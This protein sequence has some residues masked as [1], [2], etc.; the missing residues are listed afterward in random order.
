M[1]G[2]AS[3]STP[4]RGVTQAR[5]QQPCPHRPGTSP[6]AAHKLVRWGWPAGGAEGVPG[7]GLRRGQDLAGGQHCVHGG[8]RVWRVGG[9]VPGLGLRRGQSPTGPPPK[10]SV[11]GGGHGVCGGGGA[12]QLPTLCQGR[13]TFQPA[14]QGM[15]ARPAGRP[16][17]SGP[18]P[19][20]CLH[21]LATLPGFRGRSLPH[22]W[23]T[24]T[25]CQ[26]HPHLRPGAPWPAPCWQRPRSRPGSTPRRPGPAPQACSRRSSSSSHRSQGGMNGGQGR[27]RSWMKQATLASR[28]KRHGRRSWTKQ[29][30][31]PG[32]CKRQGWGGG[33]RPTL[34][35]SCRRGQPAWLPRLGQA[36]DRAAGGRRPPSYLLLPW[37]DACPLGARLSD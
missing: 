34:C 35:E 37:A 29:A 20:A 14:G 7:L 4:C 26:S 18:G 3:W 24:P 21:Q 28:G 16:C 13:C 33:S 23:C 30:A 36:E 12:A 9:G 25:S 15:Y 1:D 11:H 22:L 32:R 2:Q 10:H 17:M 6:A 31:L 5:Q 8:A 27:R 19:A